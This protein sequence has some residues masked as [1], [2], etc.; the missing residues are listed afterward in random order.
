[1]K[2]NADDVIVFVRCLGFL[3]ISLITEKATWSPDGTENKI[4]TLFFTLFVTHTYTKFKKL[5]I[6]R[7]TN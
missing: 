4:K 3:G 2:L 1:M 6:P 5:L 7:A